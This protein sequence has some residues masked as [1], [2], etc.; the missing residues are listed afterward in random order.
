MIRVDQLCMNRGNI[1][2]IDSYPEILSL[3]EVSDILRISQIT[4]RRWDNKGLLKA[5]RP[6][7]RQQRRYHKKDLVNFLQLPLPLG[8][9]AGTENQLI[10][11]TTETEK[12]YIKANGEH[13]TPEILASFVAEAI[14][15]TLD[16]ANL[17]LFKI[18]DP[19]VGDGELLLPLAKALSERGKKIDITGFDIKDEALKRAKE[20]LIAQGV[21]ADLNLIN[22][23][24]LEFAL[25][26]NSQNTFDVIISN[27][28]YVRTQ[29]MGSAQSKAISSQFDLGGRVDLYY[30]F[31]DGMARVLRPNGIAGV[32]VSNKFMKTK[33]GADVRERLM[34]EFDILHVWDFG[35]TQLFEAAVLPCVLLL[36]K[37]GSISTQQ[38]PGFTSIYSL[39]ESDDSIPIFDNV[40][41]AVEQTGK[42]R[43]DEKIFEVLHGYLSAESPADVW[44]LSTL[45]SDDWL[46]TVKANTWKEFQDLGK[47]RVGVK[48]TADN[49]FIRDDW[50]V[51]EAENI[52][53]LLKVLTTHG[54]AR[55]FRPTSASKVK[56]LYTHEIR[57][58]KRCVVDIDK[59]PESKKY[60]LKH[61]EQLASRKYVI[62]AGRAWYEIWVPHSPDLWVKP[63]II[64]RDIVKEPTFWM[65]IEGTIVNGD[66]YWLT[67]D[68][69]E[70]MDL[71]WLALAVGN[72]TFIEDFYDQKFNN[73][74]YAGRR[75][76]MTQYVKQ[77]P[78]PDPKTDLAKEIILISKQ[79]FDLLPSGNVVEIKKSL[80]TLVRAAFGVS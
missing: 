78:L 42:V 18:L 64:F 36:K 55:Q 39:R 66:C 21:E 63:K 8:D 24:F 11:K 28:P 56:I 40:I 54:I 19:A 25:D 71:L 9:V 46:Q 34:N 33:S 80:D 20:R 2:N 62:E 50:E 76:F 27:P 48:T 69:D 7:N 23:N 72:S 16:T 58:G 4:L 67:L 68:E 12:E 53:E 49:V 47:I 30:A 15:K 44:K 57:D 74:I 70:N 52:P 45:K 13:Y 10:E 31:L 41:S 75:R 32:I 59:F 37:K 6:S 29:V 60:L 77:F 51:S 14:S 22:T 3:K 65:D 17:N 43:V 5:F 38:K 79:I 35:D 26:Q 1:T 73:K 61:E